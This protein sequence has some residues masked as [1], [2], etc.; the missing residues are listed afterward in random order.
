M[1]TL[2][3]PSSPYAPTPDEIFSDNCVLSWRSPET[4]GG[5]PVIGYYVE[6]SIART[7]RWIRMTRDLVPETTCKMTDLI[8]NNE[9]QFRVIAENKVG[10][11]KP[12][13]A[14]ESIL[15]TD[16]W[17]KPRCEQSLIFRIEWVNNL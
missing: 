4:D 14:S 1:F 17:G 3:V 11:G 5:T 13:P 6:R 9:Y 12:G 2:D 16:P 10:F 7:N 8:E 15:A